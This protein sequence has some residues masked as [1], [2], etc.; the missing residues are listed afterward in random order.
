MSKRE[1]FPRDRPWGGAPPLS[2]THP[3]LC[4]EWMKMKNL[5]ITPQMVTRGSE[6]KVWWR[7]RKGPDH[8]W[9]A[10]ISNRARLGRGCPYCSGRVA[11]RDHSL[12]ALHP[13]IAA[14]WHPV[15]N[16]KLRP[17]QV[18]PNSNIKRWW[19]C[20][21][22]RSHEWQAAVSNRTKNQSATG[23]PYCSTPAKRVSRTNSFAALHPEAVKYWHPGLNGDL[24]PDQVFAASSRAC[25]WH[26][27]A[28]S[29][30]VWKA[31]P[32]HMGR[33]SKTHGCPF[34]R[35][36]RVSRTNSLTVR[37]PDFAAQWHPK[38]NGSLR[39]C[40][41]VSG[42]SRK[43]WWK[44]PKGPDHEWQAKVESRVSMNL[45]CPFCANDRVS[46]T[47]S[48]ALLHPEIAASW[49]PEK[50]RPLTPNDVVS[51][52]ARKVWWRC[53]AGEAHVWCCAVRSRALR[54]TNCPFCA[55]MRVADEERLTI[56]H[57]ELAAQFH[58]GLN[59]GLNP[60]DLSIRSY[61]SVWWRCPENRKHVWRDTVFRR[62]G[63]S[64]GCPECDER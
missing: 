40:D 64:V 62:V 46:V 14:Q 8:V 56:A 45:G 59:A 34:C 42:S 2:R 31:Q 36:V 21:V 23:C 15:K 48:F 43:A 20:A 7:C 44:C 18:P 32:S 57:P 12:A 35:G 1:Y 16:R 41:V 54:G 63:L 55:G 28:G 13:R 25:W 53:P 60:R 37:R 58:A 47:N 19:R 30:H 26:C 52:S 3:A 5:P 24:T 9:Q 11:S 38:K 4:R 49:H 50:N 6:R 33:P 22:N 61:K 29:D 39:P 17:G 27:S 10:M 51:G